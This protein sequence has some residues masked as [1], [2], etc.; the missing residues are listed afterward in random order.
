MA[1]PIA[2]NVSTRCPHS[3]APRPQMQRLTID[4]KASVKL[5]LLQGLEGRKVEAARIGHGPGPTISRS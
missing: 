2:I 4:G 5:D 1:V 3:L